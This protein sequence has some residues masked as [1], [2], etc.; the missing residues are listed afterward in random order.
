MATNAGPTDRTGDEM[1]SG[2]VSEK[3]ASENAESPIPLVVSD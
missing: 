2:T 3:K 1:M